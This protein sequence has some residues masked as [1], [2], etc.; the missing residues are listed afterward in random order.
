MSEYQKA[1]DLV[2]KGLISHAGIGELK[3]QGKINS[4]QAIHLYLLF[5]QK[6]MNTETTS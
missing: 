4:G 3:K 1:T 5:K 2:E 6:W